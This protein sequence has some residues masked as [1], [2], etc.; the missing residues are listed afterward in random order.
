MT[1]VRLGFY[2]LY[3]ILG[4]VI[5]MRL[6]SSGFHWQAV[7]GLVLAAALIA[8]GVHRIALY[9]RVRGERR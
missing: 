7:S 5:L 3:V 8:L 4:C 6:L 1:Q 2:V 9:A